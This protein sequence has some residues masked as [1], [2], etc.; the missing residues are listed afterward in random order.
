MTPLKPKGVV[1]IAESESFGERFKNLGVIAEELDEVNSVAAVFQNVNQTPTIPQLNVIIEFPAQSKWQ[2]AYVNSL[3]Y[4]ANLVLL[5]RHPP[6][7]LSL[8]R[9]PYPRA[10]I[11]ESYYRR[12]PW[13]AISFCRPPEDGLGSSMVKGIS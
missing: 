7:I 4:S 5:L 10:A 3:Y 12:S 2:D 1:P 13:Q 11:C 9:Q 8:R 6:F